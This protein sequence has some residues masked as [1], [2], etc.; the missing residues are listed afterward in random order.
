MRAET[1]FILTLRVF[2]DFKCQLRIDAHILHICTLHPQVCI[3]EILSKITEANICRINVLKL[4]V[5]FNSF[6]IN[7]VTLAASYISN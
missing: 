3:M 7:S 6:L 4:W 2:A 1:Y 5:S